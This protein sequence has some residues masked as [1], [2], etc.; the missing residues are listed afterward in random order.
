MGVRPTDNGR[1]IPWVDAWAH[2]VVRLHPSPG[3]AE[4]TDSHLGGP[5]LWPRDEPWPHCDHVGDYDLT[6]DQVRGLRTPFAGCAQLY[7]AD[8]PELPFPDARL[9]WRAAGQVTDPLDDQPAPVL[10][11]PRYV[12][13]P[14]VFNPCRAIQFPMACELL[15]ELEFINCEGVDPAGDYSWPTFGAATK[16]GGGGALNV[17][18]CPNDVHHALQL[19]VE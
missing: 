13:R 12:F 10:V 8:F 7:Q 2:P 16:I 19:W 1:E 11:D 18:V 14:C 3:E 9:V 17:F 6:D 5:M 15:H 4:R